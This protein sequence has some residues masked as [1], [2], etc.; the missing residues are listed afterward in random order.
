ML[1]SV[2]TPSYNSGQFLEQTIQSVVEQRK[3]G[4]ELEYIVIDG[5]SSDQS[6][7]ILER[8][9]KEISHIIIESDNGPANAINKG[10]AKASGDVISWLNADDVY[11]P[12]TLKRVFQTMTAVTEASL[13]FG[14]CPI[15]NENG[16]EIRTGI[17]RFKELFFPLSS[18]CTYQCINYLSQPAL[19]F[20]RSAVQQVGFLNE[21]MVAAWDYDF[22][23]RL[24][25]C[26]SAVQII[27]GPLAAFR[28]HE[29]SI[30]GQNFVIQFQEE[31][32]SVARDAGRFSVQ[33]FVHF[34]VRWGIVGVYS[35]MANCRA[36]QNRRGII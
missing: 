3:S 34:F 4:I 30:S 32:E 5:N 21:D 24:F 27:N 19:F 33:T 17:T 26:G 7:E 6:H 9:S 8:Y 22:I 23:L 11:Y 18:R 35:L 28:W 2:I 15:I 36:L 29:Q 20:R 16:L 10:L 12:D 31:Y 1:F 25:H 13:C 14:S